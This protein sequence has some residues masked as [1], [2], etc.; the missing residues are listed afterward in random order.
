[1]AS[2]GI[3]PT[4]IIDTRD[5]QR[6]EKIIFP[7]AVVSYGT[8]EKGVML[9]QGLQGEEQLNSSIENIEYNL[10]K[11]IY[12]LT[13]VERKNIVFVQG[14]GEA[15]SARIFSLQSALFNFYNIQNHTISEE[16]ELPNADL[17]IIIKPKSKWNE[18]DKYKLDQFIMK[19]GKA[20]FL[21]DQMDA[22]MDSANHERNLS[23]AYETG[24]DD[25]LF[26]YGVRINPDL[27]QDNNAALYPIVTG[28]V[29]DQPQI[30]PIPWPFFPVLNHY[31]NHPLS[32]N[33]DAVLGRFVNTIDTVKAAGIHKTPLIMTSTY[34]RSIASPAQVSVAD[35]RKNLK[36]ELLNKSYIPVA[37]LLEGS[38]T[39]VYKN[40]FLPS[41]AN[42]SSFIEK[43]IDSKVIVIGDGDLAINDVNMETGEPLPLGRFNFQPQMNFANESFLLN[44]ISYLIDENGIITAR[45]KEIKIRPLDKVKVNQEKLYWQTI[46]LL[47]PVFLVCLLGVVYVQLRKRKYSNFRKGE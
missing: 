45:N 29:G 35:L 41:N 22:N 20:L 34:S 40:R 21:I 42:K 30:T 5:G 2:K 39:S 31:G 18:E 15:D 23:F 16:P 6:T 14:H 17:A 27:V 38:F 37:W 4:N 9:L 7:G 33:M 43:G 19:G 36:P 24:L 26:R 1:L 3:Q 25:M 8:A 13:S 28:Q 32:K 44:A 46:N 10:I 47:L 12:Q 11:T